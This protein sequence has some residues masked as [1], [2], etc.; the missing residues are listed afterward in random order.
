MDAYQWKSLDQYERTEALEN[1]AHI[2]ETR[3]ESR[4]T[5]LCGRCTH[6]IIY[7]RRGYPHYTIICTALHR[8]V[9]DDISECSRYSDPHAL[10]LSQM[11]SMALDIDSRTGAGQYL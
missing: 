11:V 3:I 5:G 10:S 6:A 8:E 2:I 4:V 7:R 9:P 1:R